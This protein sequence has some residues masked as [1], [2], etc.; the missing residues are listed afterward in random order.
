M[1]F[2]Y[3]FREGIWCLDINKS[4]TLI[5]SGSPDNTVMLWD[6]KTKKNIQTLRGHPGKVVGMEINEG[7]NLL[8]SSGYDNSI[9]VWDLKG[10]KLLKSIKSTYIVKRLSYY[11]F[12]N[13]I[14]YCL[15]I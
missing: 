2:F 1:N 10:F 13:I 15:L 5:A 9:I 12:I 8:V 4:G 11:I 14:V 6:P 7:E 3:L